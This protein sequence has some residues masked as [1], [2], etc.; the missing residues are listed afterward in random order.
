VQDAHCDEVRDGT[1]TRQIL[2]GT[3]VPSD[4]C[5]QPLL[6]CSS[7]NGVVSMFDLRE[8]GGKPSLQLRCHDQGLIGM[9]IR[10]SGIL[11]TATL[12]PSASDLHF[13][14][15]RMGSGMQEST[16]VPISA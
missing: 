16:C 7:P 12:T 13:S 2:A 4:C 8:V 15:I 11:A 9:A 10:P 14:E 1:Y 3:E 5:P 6:L